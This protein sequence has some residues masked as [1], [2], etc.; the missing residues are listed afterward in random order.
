[1]NNFLLLAIITVCWTLQPF[2]KKV[3]LK[4]ISSTQFY[5]LNHVLYSIPIFLYIFYI[6]Y[7]NKLN[8]IYDLNKRDYFY[9]FL[10]VL[11]GLIGGIVFAELLKNNGASYVIPH[12]Q[13][14]I[15]IATLI[16]GYFIFKENI[17]FKHTIGVFLVLCGLIFINWADNK[18]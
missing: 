4:K 2:F 3:P 1:M 7:Q 17:T 5:I 14:L 6:S 9:C 10:I 13:P 8:F 16:V 15:I 11:V 12:V 18:Y